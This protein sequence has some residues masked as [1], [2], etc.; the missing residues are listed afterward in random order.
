MLS[1][2]PVIPNIY[3]Y[4]VDR[5]FGFAPNPFHG[6]CTLACCKP[7]L[8]STA[9]VGDWVFG[10]GGTRLKATGKCIFGM[11]ITETLTFDEYWD[12]EEYAVKKPVPNGSR[13]MM[14]GD[15]IYSRINSS[16]P[17]QQADSHHSYPDGSPNKSNIDKDTSTNKVLISKNFVYFGKEAKVVPERILDDMGYENRIGHRKFP[18]PEARGFLDWFRSETRGLGSMALGDP[19]DFRNSD[20]RY[21]AEVDKIIR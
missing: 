21:S 20:A 6:V 7:P 15:N 14:V 16:G 1:G 10:M 9:Q 4:V 5:D 12:S 3:M 19:F 2:G 18:E 11:N 13:A 17:W 8:R